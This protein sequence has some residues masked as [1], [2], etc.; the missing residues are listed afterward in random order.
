MDNMR[1]NILNSLTHLLNAS[2]T[3]ELNIIQHSSYMSDEELIQSRIH[4]KNGMSIF[5]LN[6][7]SLHAKFDY[8]KL[9]T[10]NFMSDNCPLHVICLQETWFAS[11]TDLSLYEMPGYHMIN[12]GRCA[13]NHGG[14]LI[15]LNK[16]WTYKIR[17]CLTDY[18]IWEKQIIKIFYSNST[19]RRGIIIGNIYRPPYNTRDNYD[20][21]SVEFNA[22]LQEYH[23]NSQKT[24]IC[25]DFNID[26]LKVN[27]VQFNADYFNS[28][29]SA[30]YIQTITLPTRLSDSSSLIDNI[31][32]DNLSVEMSAYILNNHISDHQPVVLFCNIDVPMHKHKY[33]TI[34]TK[35]DEAK[36]TFRS[37]FK[38]KH[39]LNKLDAESTDPNH[40]YEIL[41]VALRESLNEC[42]PT[43][44]VRFNVK[45]HKKIA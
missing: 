37:T 2:D 5:S 11:D 29:L 38:N 19:G 45:R 41:E 24:Y 18:Q 1:L 8:I 3:D 36:A 20:T 42:F 14:L 43:R 17:S 35:S 31:S 28:I 40:N 4:V 21:F 15:Y 13:S 9:L 22:M 34:Q 10:L 39:V 16:M 44:T 12:T 30:G 6:C 27:K 26:L 7:Q 32:T 25:G 23:S 33:I